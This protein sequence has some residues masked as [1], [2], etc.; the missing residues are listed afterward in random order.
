MLIIR[1]VHACLVYNW[2]V[3]IKMVLF[4][5][6][7]HLLFHKSGVICKFVSDHTFAHAFPKILINKLLCLCAFRGTWSPIF[8]LL[9]S[10][11]GFV[12]GCGVCADWLWKEHCE[13]PVHQERGDTPLHHRTEGRC[14]AHTCDSQR[15]PTWGQLRHHPYWHHQEY[16]ACFG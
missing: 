2:L 16:R 5:I 12:S 8:P 4:H 9:K 10:A 14:A 7:V 1:F 6:R 13:S 11:S 15:L 3:F